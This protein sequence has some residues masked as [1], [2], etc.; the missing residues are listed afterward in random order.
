VGGGSL[1][2]FLWRDLAKR[3]ALFPALSFAAGTWVGG[4]QLPHPA[5]FLIA[6]GAAVA[7]AALFARRV[8][9]HLLLLIGFC[10]GGV[11]LASLEAVPR[12]PPGLASGEPVRLEGVVEGATV[13]DGTTRFDLAVSTLFEPQPSPV[14]FRVGLYPSQ[15][16]PR[17]QPGQRVQLIARL[18]ELEPV[19]NPGQANFSEFRRRRGLLFSGSFDPRRVVVLSRPVAWRGWLEDARQRLS[20]RAHAVSPSPE[21]ASLYLTMA[22]GLRAELGD[23]LENQFALSGL[24]HVLS[25][26]GLH[27][28]ALAVVT[29][30]LLRSL[31]ARF[32]KASRRIDA[33]R[34]AAPLSVPFV[35]AYVA[36]TGNQTPAIRSAIMATAVF[37]AMA[38]WRRPDVL[39]SLAIAA[40]VLLAADPSAIA[41]LSLQLSFLAV[42]ALV[43]LAPAIR[44]SLPVSPPDPGASGLR[45][46]LHKIRESALQTFCAS[47]AAT[48]AG[49]PLIAASFHRISLAGL[50]SNILCLPLCGLLTILAAGGAAAFVVLPGIALPFLFAGTWTSQ[51]LLLMT[52]LFASAPGAAFAVPSPDT[53][54]CALYAS[55]LLAFALASGRWRWAAVAAPLGLA[56]GMLVRLFVPEPGLTCTFLSVGQGDAVVL[57]SR[58]RHA[59]VD[60]G[61]VPSGTDTGRKYVVPFLREIGVSKLD[62]AVLSHPH[63]DHALGLASALRE[64]PARRLWISAGEQRDELIRQVIQAAPGAVVE[65]VEAGHPAFQLGEARIDVLG[66]P[67]DRILLKSVNDRSIVLR[68]AYGSVS[69]LL[70]GD[71]EAA[72]EELLAPGP[73]T[74]VKAPHHGSRTSS[75]VPFVGQTRPRFVVFC[76]GRGNRFHFPHEEVEERYRAAG[77]HCFRTDL[78]GAVTFETDG[79]DVR[80]KTFHPHPAEQPRSAL[81]ASL[82]VPSFAP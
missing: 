17:L 40:L 14:R 10:L 70:T 28:A 58:G 60:G 25:V 78:D 80:W 76:V 5:W 57:S 26:S 47:A 68:V 50:V 79:R 81:P 49:A 15:D 3:P 34:I 11:G 52:R 64:V 9:A 2:R 59:I 8:G 35:W 69:F 71:V 56:S 32:W 53:W 46:R 67:T 38:L 22:A 30:N 18:K 24:A 12:F 33:R 75:T 27:V 37:V 13:L 73:I 48:L 36:F 72:A 7:C 43:V 44:A 29:L 63:P 31:V 16:P 21:A 23:E 42:G 82:G 41:D 62:L 61:G 54:P 55:G 77:A 74:V 6:C 65:E 20:E 19:S 51:I 4:K 1:G 66:P 45:H 39:N